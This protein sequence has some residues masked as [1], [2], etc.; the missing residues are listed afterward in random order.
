MNNYTKIFFCFTMFFFMSISVLKAEIFTVTNTNSSGAGSLMQ[1]VSDAN[2]TSGADT[3][4]FAANVRGTINNNA[5]LTPNETLSI[6]G[7]GPDLLTITSGGSGR[8]I[9]LD[10]QGESYSFSGLT[11]SGGYNSSGA[12]AGI[13]A[14][15]AELKIKNCI[16]K[17]NVNSYANTGGGGIYAITSQI[18]I[19]NSLIE[20][21]TC[22][23]AGA[24]MSLAASTFTVI[25]NSSIINNSV[26]SSSSNWGGGG[27]YVSGILVL[28]N[29]T[30]SG[31]SHPNRGGA[32]DVYGFVNLN[33]CTVTDNS[34]DACGGIYEHSPSQEDTIIVLANS[35][36]AVNLS[37][38]G[39]NDLYG[40]IYSNGYN[41]IQDQT[42]ATISGDATGNIYG[43]DPLL[44]SLQNYSP[45]IVFHQLLNGSPAMDNG[46]NAT[47]LSFDQRGIYRPQDGDENGNAVAD[48][49]AIEMIVDN[50][51]DGISDIEEKGPNGND[52]T[53]DGN[54]DGTPDW[55]QSSV[56]SLWNFNHEFYLTISQPGGYS[57]IDV[58]AIDNPS[59]ENAPNVEFPVGFFSFIIDLQ[60][61]SS[62]SVNMFFPQGVV[63]E[64]YYK[65]GQT[66]N[67]PMDHWYEF[68]YD[69]QTG[70]SI[71]QPN[72]IVIYFV[73]GERGDDDITVNGYI[74]E[75]GGPIGYVSA[76]ESEE[77]WPLNYKLEQNYPN[78]FNPS[79]KIQYVTISRQFVTL[80]V[81]D[82]LGNEVATLVN[83]EK[84]AG[85]YEVYFNPSTINHQ[86]SSGVYLCRLQTEKY[87]KTIKML[88]LK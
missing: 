21:N 43:Q 3:I 52:P 6:I 68:M 63:I 72:E 53:Y 38:T 13:F 19:E 8:V 29:C 76:V 64:D 33:G 5:T 66:P 84:L 75:P 22:N 85:I 77:D 88:Y 18:Y 40:R 39:G 74:V 17:D 71:I 31:N 41:L 14:R 57:L 67:L 2:S 30:I 44:G 46:N 36:V 69:N 25:K 73:D 34:A 7:P 12:G 78:P 26:G 9:F 24:G 81:Y 62:C 79:T 42:G 86:P 59:P 70:V 16:I 11:I 82:I 60:G 55:Q 27:I 35:I 65:Y 45:T 48:I 1:A 23:L 54:T 47:C 51:A 20:N 32:I 10:T 83:E 58:K 87:S 37:N 50:D 28:E 4:I 15:D 49:G 80:K 56:T 61:G